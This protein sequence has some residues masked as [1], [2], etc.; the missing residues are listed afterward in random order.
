MLQLMENVSW[1]SMDSIQRH[2]MKG[3]Y[4]WVFKMDGMG[5]DSGSMPFEWRIMLRITGKLPQARK[6]IDHVL[7]DWAPD[8]MIIPHGKCAES[9]AVEVIDQCLSWIPRKRDEESIRC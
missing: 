9:N 6:T 5:G 1:T 4:G 2:E 8:K 3:F 7:N